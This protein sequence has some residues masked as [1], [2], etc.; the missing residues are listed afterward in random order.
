MQFCLQKSQFIA[1]INYLLFVTRNWHATE[2][3][4]ASIIIIIGGFEVIV[5]SNGASIDTNLHAKL[6]NAFDL[7][8]T[9]GSNK[10]VHKKKQSVH[11]RHAPNLTAKTYKYVNS[12]IWL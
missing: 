9:F 4:R 6:Q 8:C 2:A 12:T 1:N 11:K 7:A 10:T 5:A 3:V